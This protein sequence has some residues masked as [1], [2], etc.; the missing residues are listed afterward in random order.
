MITS[1]R[2]TIAVTGV[3]LALAGCTGTGADPAPSATAS[4]EPTPTESSWIDPAILPLAGTTLVDPASAV[5]VSKGDPA[6][7][8]LV[9]TYG[10]GGASDVVVALAPDGRRLVLRIPSGAW[11]QDVIVKPWEYAWFDGT[12]HLAGSTADMVPG[13]TARQSFNEWTDGGTAAWVE[14]PTTSALPYPWRLFAAPRDSEPI[15]IATS[16]DAGQESTYPTIP[17]PVVY[18]GRVYWEMEAP[19]GVITGTATWSAP[20]TGGTPQMELTGA[21]N[22]AATDA[23]VFSLSDLWGPEG[24]A[25][26]EPGA[27]RVV[28]VDGDTGDQTLR[29]LDV[30]P[31]GRVGI[32]LGAGR[33]LA[34]PYHVGF[35]GGG[36]TVFSATTGEG[37]SVAELDEPFSA[38]LALCDAALVWMEP[39]EDW[40]ADT[41]YRLDLDTGELLA[42]DAPR[43]FRVNDCEGNDVLWSQTDGE[44]G[45]KQY[46][47]TIK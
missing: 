13:E 47:T 45:V 44:G 17:E 39:G 26:L 38:G 22:P 27:V 30:N 33:W 4:A 14:S 3:A 20:L 46:I 21:R 40:L 2:I 31:D 24:D 11:D 42:I 19:P 36:I 7:S 9:A 8:E 29:T 10:R 28:R 23:G 34:A 35:E 12:F 37:Y 1:S 15:L 6:T 5:R 43:A 41:I 32:L 18:D 25:G 16:D